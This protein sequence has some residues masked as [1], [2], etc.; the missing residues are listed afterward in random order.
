MTSEMPFSIDNIEEYDSEGKYD[1]DVW[2]VYLFQLFK[3]SLEERLNQMISLDE[4]KLFYEA[5]KYEYG[6]GVKQDLNK[7]LSLYINSSKSNSSNYLSMA[8]LFCIYKYETKFNI[9]KDK[10]LELIYLFKCFAYLPF[11]IFNDDMS[12]TKFPLDIKY[13]IAAFLD[14]ND[15]E[16]KYIE[17][18]LYELNKKNKYE[19]ILSEIDCN[20]AK[21]LIEGYFNY[22]N[23]EKRNSLDVLTS[24]SYSEVLEATY[25]LIKINLSKLHDKEV[26]KKEE[27]LKSKIYDLF[28][29]LEEKNYYRAFSDFGLYL[30]NEMG[31][32]EKAL[33]ILKKGYENN[34]FECSRLY[35]N[36]FTKTCNFDNIIKDNFVDIFQTTIDSFIYGDYFI[37][38]DMFD[39][40]HIMIK[41]YNL[42]NQFSNKYMKFINEIAEF[43]V[44]FTN[45]KNY[46]SNFKKYIN[47]NTTNFKY[48]IYHS[49]SSIYM[50]GLSSKFKKNLLKAEKCLKHTIK[51]GDEHNKPYYKRLI[52]NVRN[53]L[54]KIGAFENEDDLKRKGNEV[55]KSY[56]D[57]EDYDRYGNSYYYLFGRLYEK[58]IGTQKDDEKAYEY[59]QKG[60]KPL[61]NI[62][63]SFII[64]YKR[65]LS[66]KKVNLKKFDIFHKNKEKNVPKFNA[67]F[68]LSFGP[69][70]NLQ[71]NNYMTIS[72]VKDLLYKRRELHNLEIKFFLFNAKALK[73]TDTVESCRIKEN[74]VVVV[75]VEIKRNNRYN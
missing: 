12:N 29:I 6:Y 2:K 17:S 21:G 9:E 37:L 75:N 31:I 56:K 64:V 40:L 3:G 10:N 24:L 49:L 18:Y 8:R 19:D 30:Y 27:E 50:Y 65:Y 39:Y 38:G 73:D 72:E 11:Y 53:K 1:P 59:Y 25:N 45:D 71:I 23:E 34:N 63:D 22:D 70:I 14:K 58:G 26:E 5:I 28:L 61:Y 67:I 66:L 41:K 33:Q 47:N 68:N 62:Y 44:L 20:L 54:F 15:P 60:C 4:N 52:Y 16:I 57:N 46:D 51:E 74:S 69:T 13:L 32:V 43:C 42:N 7:A 48:L 55:F 35:F 36:T